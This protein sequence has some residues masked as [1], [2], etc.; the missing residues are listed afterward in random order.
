MPATDHVSAPLARRYWPAAVGPAVRPVPPSA[1]PTVASPRLSVSPSAT[2]PPPAAIPMVPVLVIVPPERPAPATS[3]VI[4]PPE[5]TSS[6]GVQVAPTYLRTCPG[7]GV[8]FATGIE[9][10]R[11]TVAL[12]SGPARSPPAAVPR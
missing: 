6:A 11:A 4:V 12:E 2:L 8:A 3:L 5:F 10:I 1:M 7:P 9:L